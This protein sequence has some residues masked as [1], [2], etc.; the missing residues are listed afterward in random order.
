MTDARGSSKNIM[1][2]IDNYGMM[3]IDNFREIP[4]IHDAS[5]NPTAIYELLN[6]YYQALD[7][8]DATSPEVNAIV[9]RARRWDK[10]T[11]VYPM[12]LMHSIIALRWLRKDGNLPA[13]KWE[14]HS[15]NGI[16]LK[17]EDDDMI[18][19]VQ[20]CTNSY[21]WGVVTFSQP[22]D[23]KTAQDILRERYCV[24]VFVF[25]YE[26]N[27]E[28]NTLLPDNKRRNNNYI[29]NLILF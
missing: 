17:P 21:Y 29:W 8:E 4:A 11:L 16:H 7:G 24:C 2:Y 22:V 10:S 9:E 1:E 25:D 19:D 28:W 20:K 6:E 23:R 18:L 12:A 14:I 5:Q 15:Q 27:V 13:T 3:D 26:E